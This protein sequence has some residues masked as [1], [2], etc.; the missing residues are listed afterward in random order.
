M[1]TIS[2]WLMFAAS[3]QFSLLLLCDVLLMLCGSAGVA[4]GVGG[5]A[6]QGV[7]SGEFARRFMAS[8]ERESKSLQCCPGAPSHLLRRGHCGVQGMKV[9]THPP[10]HFLFMRRCLISHASRA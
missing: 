10:E 5:W 4:D 8:A 3:A 1:L 6:K 7:C 9:G 2:S